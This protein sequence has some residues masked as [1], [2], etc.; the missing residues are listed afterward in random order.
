MKN[1]SLTFILCGVAIILSQVSFAGP[2]AGN[3]LKEAKAVLTNKEINS[4]L[5]VIKSERKLSCEK[6]N[7]NDVVIKKSTS[8]DEADSF[9]VAFGCNDRNGGANVHRI[10]FTGGVGLN[11]SGPA[12]VDVTNMQ[13]QESE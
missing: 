13:I 7:A 11:N 4:L 9:E 8:S 12:I 6:M 10:V 1:L 2:M 5:S 3:E